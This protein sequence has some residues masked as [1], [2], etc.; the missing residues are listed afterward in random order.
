MEPDADILLFGSRARGDATA[1][2]DW[3]F[4]ILVN[5]KVDE[6]RKDYWPDSFISATYIRTRWYPV[7]PAVAHL[8]EY[9][10]KIVRRWLLKVLVKIS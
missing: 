2:S 1:D 10:F 8:K 4:L 7:L 9:S 6:R 3:D 5:G